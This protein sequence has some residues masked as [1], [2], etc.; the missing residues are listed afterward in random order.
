MLER[1]EQNL[2][3][4]YRDRE[5]LKSRRKYHVK[6]SDKRKKYQTEIDLISKQIHEY[7]DVLELVALPKK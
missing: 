6:G 7:E 4:L 2:E 5:S 1:T 3:E